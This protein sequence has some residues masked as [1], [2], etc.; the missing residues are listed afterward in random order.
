MGFVT[1]TLS[2]AAINGFP[3]AIAFFTVDNVSDASWL[4]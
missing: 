4:A 3:W 1:A 2:K